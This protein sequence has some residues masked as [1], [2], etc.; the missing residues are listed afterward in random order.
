MSALM[1]FQQQVL[2]CTK[3][4]RCVGA[5][6]PL[7]GWLTQSGA[8]PLCGDQLSIYLRCDASGLNARYQGEMSAITQAAAELCCR[9]IAGLSPIAASD[10]LHAARALLLGHAA[11]PFDLGEFAV[12][13][14]L[15]DYPVRIKTATLPIFT[16]QAA[17]L[18]LADPGLPE[19]VISSE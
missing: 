1:Q 2:A 8:N 9:G 3:S 16:L 4:A 6:D 7:E 19:H 14:V 17:L 5:P 10:Y 12:F 13:A 18:R 11:E 15:R